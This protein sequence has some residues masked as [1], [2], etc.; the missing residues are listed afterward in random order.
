MGAGFLWA[1]RACGR[2]LGA[3]L[4]CQGPC[5]A[6]P[7]TATVLK[8]SY[9]CIRFTH[10]VVLGSAMGAATFCDNVA[11]LS[12]SSWQPPS[13]HVPGSPHATCGSA[14]AKPMS[15]RV[16]SCP[17]RPSTQA[18]RFPS[19]LPSQCSSVGFWALAH[20]HGLNPR[21]ARPCGNW[22]FVRA[23]A[24]LV[25]SLLRLIRTNTASKASLH[26]DNPCAMQATRCSFG[27]S[28]GRSWDVPVFLGAFLGRSAV[29][30][31]RVW[32][33]LLKNKLLARTELLKA[34]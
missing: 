20:A 2:S 29:L 21:G 4:R 15:S 11:R 9:V 3:A 32:D 6:D 31:S 17:L 24:N 23:V 33:F 25:A 26:H 14:R 8:M 5:G 19:P 34:R 22:T 10:A 16:P 1:Q 13:K 28:L 27:T 12:P 18:P 7:K 30:L